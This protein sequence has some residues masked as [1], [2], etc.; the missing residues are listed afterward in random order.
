MTWCGLLFPLQQQAEKS[1]KSV[2][3][4]LKSVAS[5][6]TASMCVDKVMSMLWPDSVVLSA[7][8][9]TENM[10]VA[11]NEAPP[12]RI[13]EIC[14]FCQQTTSNDDGT[15]VGIFRLTIAMIHVMK[16][17]KRVKTA[18]TPNTTAASKNHKLAK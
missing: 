15:G 9:R 11:V 10:I 14:G 4:R 16:L 17:M 7:P 5:Q 18:R 3:V 13:V 2:A 1:Q 6:V 12:T 8:T